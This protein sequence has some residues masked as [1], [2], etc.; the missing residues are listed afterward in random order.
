MEN[1]TIVKAGKFIESL[2]DVFP[3]ERY[4]KGF[5]PDD[6]AFS[7]DDEIRVDQGYIKHILDALPNVSVL[8]L[9]NMLTT[10]IAEEIDSLLIFDNEKENRKVFKCSDI[11]LKYDQNFEMAVAKHYLPE[12]TKSFVTN[13][14]RSMLETTKSLI[15][16]VRNF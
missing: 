5:L 8:D 11:A 2:K 12:D 16:K 14:T 4:I 9:G 7:L 10:K 6:V 1:L 3:M 13:F 15:K